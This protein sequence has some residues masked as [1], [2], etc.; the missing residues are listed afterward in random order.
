MEQETIEKV[1]DKYFPFAEKIGGETYTGYK[2]FIAGAKWQQEQMYSEENVKEMLFM[3][4][5]EP[6]EECCTT[7]TKDS[8]VRKV[9]KTFKQQETIKDK[10]CPFCG[11]YLKYKKGKLTICNNCKAVR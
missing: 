4:L 2:G 1:A 9:L 11:S 6:K 5:Y 3:A 8:I 10:P 7:Y